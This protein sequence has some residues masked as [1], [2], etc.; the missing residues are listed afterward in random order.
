MAPRQVVLELP[1][2][3]IDLQQRTRMAQHHPRQGGGGE[4]QAPHSREIHVPWRTPLIQPSPD[5]EAAA[6]VDHRLLQ[7]GPEAGVLRLDRQDRALEEGPLRRAQRPVARQPTQRLVV[8]L[9]QAGVILEGPRTPGQ[10]EEIGG[11]YGIQLHR[12]GGGQPQA[13]RL[14]T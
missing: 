12:R 8:H 1:L 5:G 7:E 14:G 3:A 9:H 13:P 10:C 11:F 2:L 6:A 4:D